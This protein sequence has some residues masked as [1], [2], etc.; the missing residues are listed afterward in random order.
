MIRLLILFLRLFAY[1][2]DFELLNGFVGGSYPFEEFAAA[3]AAVE[4]Q[5]EPF[6]FLPASLHRVAYPCISA[7]PEI[8]AEPSIHLL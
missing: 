6:A 4:G 2:S 5:V 1:I 8:I 7:H 3:D